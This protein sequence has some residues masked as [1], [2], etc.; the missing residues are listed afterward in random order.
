MPDAKGGTPGDLFAEVKVRLP[1]PLDER[2]RRL[3]RE[4]AESSG[5]DGADGTD[6]KGATS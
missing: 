5:S 1:L 6:A 2:T 4:L 3:A